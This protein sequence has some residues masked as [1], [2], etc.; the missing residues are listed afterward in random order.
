MNKTNQAAV[1]APPLANNEELQQQLQTLREQLA[2]CEEARKRAL[3]DFANLQKRTL[4]ERQQYIAMAGVGILSDLIGTVD[5]LEM[6]VKHF[7]DPSLKMIVDELLRKLNDHGL[8]PMSVLGM[9]FDPQTME[10]VET[11]PGKPNEVVAVQQAGYWLGEQ[12]LRPAKVIVG[13]NSKTAAEPPQ[14][15]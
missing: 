5:H 14:K 4:V 12:V 7:P 1:A 2:S 6:A 9:A 13:S 8:R 15:A 11:A 10:A 3:A